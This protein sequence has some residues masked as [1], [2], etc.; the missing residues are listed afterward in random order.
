MARS[1]RNNKPVAVLLMDLDRFKRINDRYGHPVGDQALRHLAD[2]LKEET[3]GEDMLGRYGGEE[4]LIVAPDADEEGAHT[5]AERIR[6]RVAAEPAPTESGELPLTVSI[7]VALRVDEEPLDDLVARADA[8]L[9]QAKED[10]RNRIVGEA[11]GPAEPAAA[12]PS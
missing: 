1:S 6:Q 8:A 10:G 7:G 4:F 3:R 11:A 12:V 9:L 5:L 2:I